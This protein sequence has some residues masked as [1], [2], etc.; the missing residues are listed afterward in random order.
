MKVKQTI[1]IGNPFNPN[2]V[3]PSPSMEIMKRIFSMDLFREIAPP[4]PRRIGCGVCVYGLDIDFL[5]AP[6]PVWWSPFYGQAYCE[7]HVDNYSK[8][9]L[10][11]DWLEVRY[12]QFLGALHINS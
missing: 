6:E 1:N 2:W 8:R 10:R 7:Q 5:C 11:L 12:G 3:P 4:P 9:L